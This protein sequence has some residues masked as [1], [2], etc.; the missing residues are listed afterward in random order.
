MDDGRT[1]LLVL[2]GLLVAL[3]GC[4]GPD[5]R[6]PSSPVAARVVP[7]PDPV[8]GGGEEGPHGVAEGAVDR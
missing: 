2:A 4:A 7:A 8:A 6:G 3:P 5:D 1:R